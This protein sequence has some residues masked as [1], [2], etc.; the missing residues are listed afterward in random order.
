M[1]NPT[2]ITNGHLKKWQDDFALLQSFVGDSWGEASEIKRDAMAEFV[3]QG[4]PSTKWE[5]WKYTSVRSISERKNAP[6]VRLPQLPNLEKIK[7]FFRSRAP[8]N[9]QSHHVVLVDG[10]F[11][12]ELSHIH[13]DDGLTILPLKEAIKNGLTTPYFGKIADRKATPFVALNTAM[14]FDGVFIHLEKNQTARYPVTVFHLSL[15][16]GGETAT[17]SRKLIVAEAN[18]ELKVV[19]Q[20]L[21]WPGANSFET[22]VGEIQLMAD[23]RVELST[24]QNEDGLELINFTQVNQERQSR[25]QSNVVTLR[26]QLIRN[27]LHALHQGEHCETY[28]NGLYLL[29]GRAHVDNHTL[30]D[31][32]LPN[33]YSNELYKGVLSGEATAVFNGKVMVRPDAQK[34]NAFQSNKTL[35]LSDGATI[36]TKPQL[37]IFADDVKCSHGATTGQL[38]ETAMFY[39]RSRGL[40]KKR[41]RVLLTYAFASEVID[42]VTIPELKDHL[43]AYVTERL[44]EG[45]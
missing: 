14:A 35:I 45:E 30:V 34:T 39:L 24:I 36:N 7:T 3:R 13:E 10:H 43:S 26:G 31:H 44:L 17:Y 25:F 41:A 4:F 1:S 20:W 12:P 9:M 32:A 15:S 23:A 2:G 21:Q 27:N 33:C 8:Q 40:D 22:H 6:V 42:K 29:D 28:M 38:D 11:H 18:S 37:E 16:P 5:E 19:E